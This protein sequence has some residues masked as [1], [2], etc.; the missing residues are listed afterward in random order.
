MF[1]QLL[2]LKAWRTFLRTWWRMAP[3]PIMRTIDVFEESDF[4]GALEI[5]EIIFIV[6]G[7]LTVGTFVKLNNLEQQFVLPIYFFVNL[8]TVSF[9][10]SWLARRRSRVRRNYREILIMYILQATVFLPILVV[11]VPL[12]WFGMPRWPTPTIGAFAVLTLPFYYYMIRIWTYFWRLETWR[13]LR[14]LLLAGLVGALP[15][16]LLL[17]PFGNNP[18]TLQRRWED[19]RV[20]R[21]C[22][23]LSAQRYLLAAG[24]AL[25][26]FASSGSVT[27]GRDSGA[28]DLMAALAEQAGRPV[29]PASPR[30]RYLAA[31]PLYL[32]RDRRISVDSEAEIVRVSD[33]RRDQALVTTDR[34][35]AFF[36]AYIRQGILQGE[37]QNHPAS[38]VTATVAA[39]SH[40]PPPPGVSS[41]IHLDLGVVRD[42]KAITLHYDA[43]FV[44]AGHVESM[45]SVSYLGAADQRLEQGVVAQLVEK[46]HDQLAQAERGQP[47]AQADD[48]VPG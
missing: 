5:L 18:L 10:F 13:V 14:Y 11:T 34:A 6:T 4:R 39:A 22:G 2:Q 45:A 41:V 17:V 35:P 43:F 44:L 33:L 25:S 37:H 27:Q 30:A 36:G 9:L 15:G 47:R 8:V 19:E 28:G 38:A 32:S 20:N 24:P 42:G 31:A 29:H 23:D 21:A 7:L 12:L 48:L 26:G 46:I 3:S 40:Q 16:T 1:D